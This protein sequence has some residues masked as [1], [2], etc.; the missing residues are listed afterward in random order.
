MNT[1][2][3]DK[4]SS[5]NTPTTPIA[6]TTRVE[7]VTPELAAEGLKRHARNR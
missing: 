7:T 3:N 5:L 6:E 2:K 1:K 4:Q